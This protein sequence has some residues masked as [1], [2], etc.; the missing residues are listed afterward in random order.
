MAMNTSSTCINSLTDDLAEK[1]YN[2]QNRKKNSWKCN[3]NHNY[4]KNYGHLGH[5]LYDQT[6]FEFKQLS[7]TI[8]NNMVNI[9][10]I[11]AFCLPQSHQKLMERF[12]KILC[13]ITLMGNTSIGSSMNLTRSGLIDKAIIIIRK[14]CLIKKDDENLLKTFDIQLQEIE[15]IATNM[16]SDMGLTVVSSTSLRILRSPQ[17]TV[18]NMLPYKNVNTNMQYEPI[19]ISDDKSIFVK[20]NYNCIKA[21]GVRVQMTGKIYLKNTE[22]VN[23]LGRLIGPRGSTIKDLENSTHSKITI[24]GRGSM[25]NSVVEEDLYRQNVCEHLNEP[26][27]ILTTVHATSEVDC[28][29]KLEYAR[30][31]IIY[32]LCQKPSIV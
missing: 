23:V 10:I 18:I 16:A 26:L 22:N 9:P 15:E 29:R 7:T 6:S 1:C 31:K 14:V 19:T 28:Y 17:E 27:H 2:K 13:T 25:R 4:I 12:Y 24:R 32:T 21:R 8:K 3:D 20:R 30:K 11:E 5:I